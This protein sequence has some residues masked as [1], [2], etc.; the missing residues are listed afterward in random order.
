[1]KRSAILLLVLAFGCK[2]QEK[3]QNMAQ[4]GGGNAC[5]N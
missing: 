5:G 2:G 3:F 4:T 1:M